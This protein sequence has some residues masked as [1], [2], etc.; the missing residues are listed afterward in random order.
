MR[1]GRGARVGTKAGRIV[2][3]VRILRLVRIMKLYKHSQA[4]LNKNEDG[5][6]V[7]KKSSDNPRKSAPIGANKV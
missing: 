5:K 7:N 2:R 6:D 1:A 4:A 3:I